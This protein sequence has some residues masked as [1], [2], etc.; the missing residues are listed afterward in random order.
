MEKNPGDL[1]CA[2]MKKSRCSNCAKMKKSRCA[3]LCKSGENDTT[4]DLHKN[5]IPYI[6]AYDIKL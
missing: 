5:A 3:I 1:F 2:K 6:F 4:R